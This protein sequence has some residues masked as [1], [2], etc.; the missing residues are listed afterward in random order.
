[1]ERVVRPL[2]LLIGIQLMAT[3]VAGPCKP[4]WTHPILCISTTFSNVNVHWFATVETEK[5]ESVP[6]K[7]VENGGHLF[8]FS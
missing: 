5:E 1:M 6:L 2:M 8:S 7:I 3:E 4:D